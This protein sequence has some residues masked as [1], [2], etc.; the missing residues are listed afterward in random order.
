[1]GQFVVYTE[2]GG[3]KYFLRFHDAFYT[4]E[5]LINNATDFE[6]IEAA[7]ESAPTDPRFEVQP[8]GEQPK[9]QKIP[10]RDR[11][12]ELRTA[13]GHTQQ[14]VANMLNLHIKTYQ[15]YEQGTC[16][17]TND[18]IISL[19]KFFGITIQELVKGKMVSETRILC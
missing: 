19:A 7:R 16:F 4:L 1:M 17:P 8:T 3:F 9:Y 2:I 13:A 18:G 14:Q 15:A 10:L 12:K 5:G 11:L 6:T